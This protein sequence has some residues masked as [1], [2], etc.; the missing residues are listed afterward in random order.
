MARRHRKPVTL[1]AGGEMDR[2]GQQFGGFWSDLF[3]T[4]PSNPAPD[5]SNSDFP[6]QATSDPN[7]LKQ[8]VPT[9]T[10][11][12]LY[13]TGVTRGFPSAMYDSWYFPTGQAYASGNAQAAMDTIT[14]TGD[15]IG[16]NIQAVTNIGANVV[17]NF[18]PLLIGIAAIFLLMKFGD[19]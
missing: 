4:S 5:L 12:P 9:G 6:P 3:G 1:E 17:Q 2:S 14:A 13:V 16:A 18:V 19:K 7:I 10:P 11:V 15:Q 8:I